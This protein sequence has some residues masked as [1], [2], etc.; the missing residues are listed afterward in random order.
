ME[1]TL[2]VQIIGSFAQVFSFPRA[3]AY[4]DSGKVRVKGMVGFSAPGTKLQLEIEPTAGDRCFF[5][6][7]LPKSVG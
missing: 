7:R 4:L 5:C 3:V 6:Q 1:L 2:A